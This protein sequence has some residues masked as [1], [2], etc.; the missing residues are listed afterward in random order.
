MYDTPTVDRLWCYESSHLRDNWR[1]ESLKTILVLLLVSLPT[2]IAS[3][4]D[5][6]AR[7]G[8]YMDAAAKIERFNGSVL[9]AKDGKVVFAKGYGLANA[10]HDVPNTPETRFRLGSI[11]KQFTATAIL[12]LRD[13][14]KLTLDDPI[15]K[16]LTDAP[17]SWDGVTVHHLL[18]HTSGIPSYT[19]SPIYRWR[20]TNPET[21][22]SMISR[23][24]DLPLEFEPSSKFKYSNSGYFLLGAIIEKVSGKSYE[25]FL[26]ESIFDPLNMHDSGYDRPSK[27]LARRAAGYDRQGDTLANTQY[28]DMNQPYAAGSLY[29]TVGDLFKWDRALKDGKLLSQQSLVAMF[30]PFKNNYA[31]GWIV[32]DQNGRVRI[33]HGG[34]IN[35]F[36]TDFQR[37]PEENVCVVVLCNVVPADPGKV[38]G[39]LAAIAFG[40]IVELPTTREVAE[41]DP[42]VYD[43]YVG[44]YTLTSELTLTITKEDDRLF[45][46][47]TG[48]SK[49]ELFPESETKFFLKVIDARLTFVRED[50]KVTHVILNHSGREVKGIRVPAEP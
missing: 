41:I 29:S 17:K 20:M 1:V 46:Q 38:A 43:N 30:Q 23:F 37:F 10:E 36:A 13:Q 15:S 50:G 12:L 48:Q 44:K 39:D 22:E 40:E 7:I 11:T 25:T 6:A 35:G 31:Y 28:L 9:L 47:P 8:E 16:H 5:V 49:A 19:D 4:D 26:Q 27:V 2:C 33:G 34:G 24:K 14:G 45:G 18:T 32:E 42:K 21:V 3:A